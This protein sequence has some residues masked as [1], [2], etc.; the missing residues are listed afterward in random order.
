MNKRHFI[1]YYLMPMIVGLILVGLAFALPPP[2]DQRMGVYD[3]LFGNLVE[4]NCRGCHALGVPDSHHNLVRIGRYGCTN[5]HPVL[6]NGSGITLIR[7]CL[8]CHDTTFNGM[9]I[10]RPHHETQAAMVG[11]CNAC[12]GSVVDNYDD[13]HYIPTSPPSS[14]APDTKFKVINQTSGRKWGGCESC[15]EANSTASPPIAYNNK[16]HHRLGNLSGFRNNDITKCA[17]CHDMHNATYGSD[18]IRYCERC[19]GYS[20][21]HNI[22]W[23]ITNTTQ[24]S[25]YGHLGP[26]DCQGCHASYVAGSLAPGADLIVPSIDHLSTNLVL[27]GEETELTIHGDDFVTTVDGITRSSVVALTDGVIT[28]GTTTTNITI[29]PTNITASE[30]VVTIP[31]LNKGLYAIYVIKDGNIESNKRPLAAGPAMIV[32]SAIINSTTVAINGS[33]FGTYDP[34]YSNWTNVTININNG[35][36]FRSVQ[37][38]NWSETSINVTSPDAMTGDTATVNSMYGTNSTQVTGG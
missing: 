37:V 28:N 3:N 22:Q 25:G 2:V 35:T 5:C 21:L 29:T 20:S 32:N 7:N 30:I 24:M 14:M 13:G 10:R 17:M 33:G 12:H 23:D 11:H 38:I 26:N 15:H 16:T 36:I 27:I 31:P 6:P 9:A 1:L 4:S 18:S 34:A 19:H 8:Q